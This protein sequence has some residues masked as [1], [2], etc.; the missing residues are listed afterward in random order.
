M[1]VQKEGKDGAQMLTAGS[2]LALEDSSAANYAAQSSAKAEPPQL[3]QRAPRPLR[4]LRYSPLVHHFLKTQ[5]FSSTNL[6]P[7]LR[8][9]LTEA[10]EQVVLVRR[11]CVGINLGENGACGLW[12]LVGFPCGSFWASSRASVSG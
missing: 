11:V 12:G 8:I 5:R 6:V 9:A 4:T 7:E 10:E 2:V 3:K 1:T